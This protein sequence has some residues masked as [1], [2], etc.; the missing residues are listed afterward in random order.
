MQREGGGKERRCEGERDGGMEEGREEE[1]EEESV[2]VS[3]EG[4]NGG[5]EE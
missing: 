4:G 2:E 5:K 3:I 1:I